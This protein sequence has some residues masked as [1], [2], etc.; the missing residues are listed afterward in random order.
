MLTVIAIYL[1]TGLLFALAFAALGYKVIDPAASGA[2]IPVRLLWMPGA[3]LLWPVLL[4]K[5]IRA[6]RVSG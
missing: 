4:S 2:G 1:G 5:W 3:L 6:K